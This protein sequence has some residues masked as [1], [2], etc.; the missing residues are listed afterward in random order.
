VHNDVEELGDVWLES[1]G[2]HALTTDALRIDDAIRAGTHQLGLR[3]I[4]AGS[5]D[6]EQVRTE[7]SAG[8]SHVE[9]VGVGV[10]R[11]HRYPGPLDPRRQERGVVGNVAQHARVRH[12]LVPLGV[13]VDNDDILSRCLHEAG[14]RVADTSPPAHDDVAGHLGDLAVHASPPEHVAQLAFDERFQEH[15]EGRESC[16]H[17]AEDEHDGEG[18]EP[19]IERPHFAEADRRDRCDRLVEGVKE[20]ETEQH[21]ADGAGDDDERERTNAE[22]DPPKWIGHTEIMPSRAGSQPRQV[23]ADAPPKVRRG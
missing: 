23:D 6:D 3:R 15:A 22:P 14:D 5:G 19:G 8:Q 13:A 18:L 17:A 16:A 4:R 7:G 1:E 20:R 12:L 2:R 11:T 9:V 21:V 10:E